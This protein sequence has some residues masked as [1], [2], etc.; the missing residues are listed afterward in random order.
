MPSPSKQKGNSYE[1][2]LV[3]HALEHGITA[4][5]AYA[6]NGQSLG[7]AEDVDCLIGTK[8]IQCKRRARIAKWLTP[9][10][11]VDAVAVRED[12]GETYIVMKWT[13]YLSLIGGKQNV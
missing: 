13:E 11:T 2:E 7:Y 12:R 5:R 1:R 9:S 4:K 10:S 8:R 3:N 6:S